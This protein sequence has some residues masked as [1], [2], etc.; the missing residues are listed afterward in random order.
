M[1]LLIFVH[2]FKYNIDRIPLFSSLWDDE[3]LKTV[4]KQGKKLDM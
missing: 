3:C 4:G 2:A 1:M